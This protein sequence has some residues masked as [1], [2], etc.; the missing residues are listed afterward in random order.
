EN[1]RVSITY[2]VERNLRAIKLNA[3]ALSHQLPAVEK[4]VHIQAALSY[5]QPASDSPE[6]CYSKQ[7]YVCLLYTSR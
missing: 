4:Q 6:A 7:Y 5:V 2:M 3:D 1:L